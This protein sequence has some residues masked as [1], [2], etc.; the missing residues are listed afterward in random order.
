MK[1]HHFYLSVFLLIVLSA[2]QPIQ[3]SGKQE[4]SSPVG[5]EP[6]KEV[7]MQDLKRPW[8]MAFLSN[9][10]ALVAE[11]DG[12]LLRVNISTKSKQIITGFPNDLADSL[13]IV[14][15]NY[16]KGTYPFK[17]DGFK[18]RYNAGIF[19]IVLDPDYDSNGWVYI[20]YASEKDKQFATKVIRAKIT[21]DE[22]VEVETLLLALPYVDGLFHFGGGMVFGE[23][24]KLYIT[25]GERLFT[26][27]MQ[28][29]IPIA[30]N[31][32]DRRGKIYRLNSDGSIPDDN[33]DFGEGAVEGMFAAG[34]RAAQ[35]ITVDPRT[36]D[37]WFTEH[38]THQGDEL[39]MLANGAN[40]GWPI[41]S[42]GRYRGEYEPP[43]MERDFASPKWSWF[44][45]IA[46]TGLTF[47][48][49]TEF[50]QWKNN[51]IVPGLSKGNLWRLVI[52]EDEIISVEELFINE[53]HRT[54]KAVQSPDGQLYILTDYADGEIIRIKNGD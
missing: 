22:I 37:I 31:Y 48:T 10:E 39:N 53:R 17:S 41:V 26:D 15:A 36:N 35:G 29:S 13:L 11:K 20:S 23:D 8:S 34:I 49:G 27:G 19:E 40:Y 14:E 25:I 9:D 50:P 30:Q 32:E 4:V 54:R 24:G 21:N 47:Y 3:D 44:K 38:G 12:D 16:P 51:L 43:K 28:P 7:V 1:A 33:P 5:I 46:P 6:S 45:T 18:G 42:T 52:R 2:C